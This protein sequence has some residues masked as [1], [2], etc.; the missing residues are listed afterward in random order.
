MNS[1]DTAFAA[2]V[3]PS[4]REIEAFLRQ[5][6]DF[7]A[8]RPDL[9]RAMTPP[10]RFDGG[11]QISDFQAAMIRGLRLDVERLSRTSVDLV[12]TSQGNLSRQQRTHSA[13]LM[14]AEAE[15][16][17][18]FHR[19]L[20][21]DWPQILDVDAIAL[22][23]ED[24]AATDASEGPEGI[25]RVPSGTVDAL[26]AKSP[27]PRTLLTPERRGNRLFGTCAAKIHSDALVRLNPQPGGNRAAPE[28]ILA[29]G[30]FLPETFHP[31]QATDLLEFL[32]RLLA[33]VLTRW[34][35]PT[36]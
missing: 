23:L 29:V 17:A 1:A 24:D 22:I 28:G 25:L 13:A 21:R 10:S 2:D 7:L 16:P 15:T 5:H 3:L 6:P 20:I 33:I 8:E 12:A 14:L 31:G 18:D 9:L 34:C 11:D 36:L 35:A 26:F 27:N 32:A 19:V 30:A 4:P